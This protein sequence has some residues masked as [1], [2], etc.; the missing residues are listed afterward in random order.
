VPEDKTFFNKVNRILSDR[1]MMIHDNKLDWAMAELL[2]YGSLLDEGH[3]VRISGQDSERGT[4]AH[5]H[6]SFVVAD[7]DENIFR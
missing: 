1:R 6:A 4:F 2:A 5:R 3:P 7:M